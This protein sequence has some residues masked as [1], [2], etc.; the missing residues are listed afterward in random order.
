MK[1]KDTQ[2]GVMV[3][4]RSLGFA[5][6]FDS[7]EAFESFVENRYEDQNSTVSVKAKNAVRDGIS[8]TKIW[9]LVSEEDGTAEAVTGG[10]YRS[11]R[12]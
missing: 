11:R 5:D 6:D 12:P 9:V 8:S 7:V 4:P 10:E 1:F 2:R 3:V